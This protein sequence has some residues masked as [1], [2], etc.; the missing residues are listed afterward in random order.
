MQIIRGVLVLALFYPLVISAKIGQ[1][2]ET[3]QKDFVDGVFEHNIYCTFRS[4]HDS[5]PGDIEYVPRWDF[6]ND[7]Y[8]DLVVSNIVM[9]GAA[10]QKDSTVLYLG[11]PAP[12]Y[13]KP[14]RHI[15]YRTGGSAEIEGADLNYDGYPELLISHYRLWGDSGT[16]GMMY[17]GVTIQWGDS[18]SRAPSPNRYDTL[19][20]SSQCEALYVADLNKDGHLD[21]I[22]SSYPDINSVG[23]FWGTDQGYSEDSVT[24][25]RC[26]IPRHN[27]EV[28][29]F[30]KDGYYDI[31]VVNYQGTAVGVD[32]IAPVQQPHYILWGG[33]N[34]Y[35]TNNK[36]DLMYWQPSAHGMTVADLDNNGWLDLVFTGTKGFRRA[37][38]YWGEGPRQFSGPDSLYPGSCFGGSSAIDY[39]KDGWLDLI[40]FV[41]DAKDPTAVP[42]SKLYYFL[43][44]PSG[45]SDKNKQQLG[46]RD[47]NMSGGFIA[48]F[49]ND[50]AVDIFVHNWIQQVDSSAVV[51]GPDF[52]EITQLPTN[53]DHH[54][55]FR[56]VGNSYDR[57]YMEDY[58]SSVY[59]ADTVVN[60]DMVFWTDSTP[61]K[62]RVGMSVRTGNSPNPDGSWSG[63]FQIPYKP[64][65]VPDSLNSRYLQY[66]AALT[67]STPAQLPV[68][69]EVRI[70]Y[71]PLI[72]VEPDT[73][74]F[75]N[76][77][78]AVD[79]KMRV[80]NKGTGVD[81]IDI[82]PPQGQKPGW[83]WELYDALDQNP[84]SNT[85]GDNYPDVG[86]V[87][88]NETA[89]FFLKVTP[90]TSAN[91]GD[92]DS[93]IVWG[94]SSNNTTVKD[95]AIVVTV[96]NPVI[97]VEVDPS[98][99]DSCDPG[100]SKEYWLWVTNKGNVIE[101]IDLV[102]RHTTSTWSAEL[103]DVTRQPLIDHNNDSIP[104]IPDVRPYG[105][106]TVRFIARITPPIT[107]IPLS[108]D[109]T[110]VWAYSNFDTLIAPGKQGRDTVSLVTRIPLRNIVI[111]DTVLRL[112]V[113]PDTFGSI[114]RPD[115][116]V[117]YSLR[118]INTSYRDSMIGDSTLGFVTTRLDLPLD[119]V[120]LD[121]SAATPTAFGPWQVVL[122]DENN[123]PLTDR[124]G[125]GIV[126][127]GPVKA[128][129]NNFKV[130]MTAPPELGYLVG[131]VDTTNTEYSVV[132]GKAVLNT[133]KSEDSLDVTT[134]LIPPLDV[135][136][137]PNP[138]SGTT[139]FVFSLP[140][141]GKVT[142]RL[143]N[144]AGE[145]V[146][147]LI[148][149]KEYQMGVHAYPWD[150]KNDLGKTVAPG[151]YLY[152]FYF[153]GIDKLSSGK[154]IIKKAVAIP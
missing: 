34:G 143:F 114:F 101:T 140:E 5:L 83:K 86:G 69:Y 115:S 46:P 130:R 146:K 81:T 57:S 17:G 51:W 18:A 77:G 98:Q 95:S 119:W 109:T 71:N 50:G 138:F 90:S 145:F 152:P 41:G 132:K 16:A 88:P 22:T 11:G 128:G 111:I 66:K 82:L 67:Y 56:E 80:I 147:L 133:Y 49:N 1:W 52:T 94:V 45:F 8:I 96:I 134:V 23:I 129:V 78:A 121:L 47:F 76:P 10:P 25:I 103:L 74:S 38:I 12:D 92:V 7:G 116:T 148:K 142:L 44:G 139:T 9:I 151:V 4:F 135:H 62:S 100:Q 58:V 123:K 59:D 30:D 6:N 65:P 15:A 136:N 36:T 20:Q 106:D 97:W 127:L 87:A 32:T 120:D 102:P 28:A 131:E 75:T 144:R 99:A 24:S 125:N 105:Q 154:T 29:D 112:Q 150:G 53:Q 39:N 84:L 137:F 104:D 118:L 73:M 21:V 40:F 27:F 43:G 64:G 126:D 48:D 141:D 68:L 93:V 26:I 149:E 19:P 3:T 14:S 33:P 55:M 70:T 113:E 122:L 153:K 85:D 117:T 2:V 91:A 110:I 108:K 89:Y 72:V 37:Y 79:Y 124:T 13:F 42:I 60:W 31:A 54:G 61:G 63:W 107:V 35:S